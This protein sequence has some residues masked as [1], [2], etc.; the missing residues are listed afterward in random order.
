MF[1]LDMESAVY[2][3]YLLS[4]IK[5]LFIRLSIFFAPVHITLSAARAPLL[6]AVITIRKSMN[7]AVP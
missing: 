5:V 3:I 4:R 1:F 7:P 2:F 6:D